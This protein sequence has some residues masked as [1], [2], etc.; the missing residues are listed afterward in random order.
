MLSGRIG[1]GGQVSRAPSEV[2]KIVVGDRRTIGQTVATRAD[3]HLV[4]VKVRE[5]RAQL[6]L[7]PDQ[8]LWKRAESRATRAA[9]NVG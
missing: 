8:S 9:V 5:F 3:V 2:M 4:Q 7:L 6:R 1:R